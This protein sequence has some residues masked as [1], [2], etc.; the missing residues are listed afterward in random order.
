MKVKTRYMKPI[1]LIIITVVAFGCTTQSKREEASS[2]EPETVE[3]VKEKKEIEIEDFE[4]FFK[5][6]GEDSIFQ[7]TRIGFPIS[8][9]TVDIE[10]NKEEYVY[11]RDDFWHTDFTQDVDAATQEIDQYE[12]VTKKRS[13]TEITYIRM[14]IDNGIRIEYYFEVDPTGKWQLIKI[15]DSSN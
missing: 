5:R 4:S 9:Y 10:D 12:P 15:I 3:T 2:K 13:D 8:Y 7:F 11:S 1:Y 6:F 14:G